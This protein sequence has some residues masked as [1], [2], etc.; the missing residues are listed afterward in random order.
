MTKESS[1]ENFQEL[2]GAFRNKMSELDPALDSKSFK[3]KFNEI[4]NWL[5][6]QLAIE[7]ESR[8]DFNKVAFSYATKFFYNSSL[9]K[10]IPPYQCVR[11]YDDLHCF[12]A[13]LDPFEE[14]SKSVKYQQLFLNFHIVTLSQKYI[15]RE[16]NFVHFPH[17]LGESP[18]MEDKI[19][20]LEYLSNCEIKGQTQSLQLIANYTGPMRQ[21]V[22]PEFK[23]LLPNIKFSKFGDHDIKKVVNALMNFGKDQFSF[24]TRSP[25]FLLNG[26]C[27]NLS[28]G[29]GFINFTLTDERQASKELS[30]L[31][32]FVPSQLNSPKSINSKI[33]RLIGPTPWNKYYDRLAKIPDLRVYNHQGLGGIDA[34]NMGLGIADIMGYKIAQH[35]SIINGGK[36]KFQAIESCFQRLGEFP[37]II[38]QCDSSFMS[39]LL[40]RQII[41]QTAIEAV[42]LSARAIGDLVLEKTKISSKG[43]ET[44]LSAVENLTRIVGIGTCYG[45]ATALYSST[46]PALSIFINSIDSNSLAESI[47]A[48][49]ALLSINARTSLRQYRPAEGKLRQNSLA[50]GGNSQE[51]SAE[52]T[53]LPNPTPKI[54]IT[55]LRNQ[56]IIVFSIYT[57]G[58]FMTS[59]FNDNSLEDDSQK[60]LS[61]PKKILA[62]LL[63]AGASSALMGLSSYALALF[64]KNPEMANQTQSPLDPELGSADA[65]GVRDNEVLSDLVFPDSNR[66]PV[67]APSPVLTPAPSPVLAP[68]PAPVLAPAPAP[69]LAPAPVNEILSDLVFS[70]SNRVPI[71]APAPAQTQ[72][73]ATLVFSARAPF[74][75]SSQPQ[76]QP[77]VTLVFP[78]S[79][80]ASAR[81]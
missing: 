10:N 40:R 9:G 45:S 60:K 41:Q 59:V 34:E 21:E 20:F 28:G 51:P 81:L 1:V 16:G 22:N 17:F 39:P 38:E 69:V 42:A 36:E 15:D 62:N 14:I 72:P 25:Q 49:S 67:E 26:T 58:Q 37:K 55:D 12:N 47:G 43:K 77:S 8:F 48:G 18:S 68:A 73:S 74:S 7:S 11:Q 52:I 57:L 19:T 53:D 13:S 33:W 35:L 46:I 24:M 61:F 66:V 65:G 44:I 64:K 3:V 32:V 5:Q 30:M 6:D 27:S 76:T 71:E 78:D 4:A 31:D 56:A 54:S 79:A 80:Q 75:D 23:A 63:T 70:D 50:S 2:Y 29:N